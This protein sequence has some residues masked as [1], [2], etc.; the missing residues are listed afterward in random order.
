LASFFAYSSIYKEQLEMN[1]KKLSIYLRRA[2][3]SSIVVLTVGFLGFAV[4]AFST[5]DLTRLVFAGVAVVSIGILAL[6]F[7]LHR[8]TRESTAYS[9][10]RG[11]S[12]AKRSLL[13]RLFAWRSAAV[14]WMRGLGHSSPS[15]KASVKSGERLA[16]EAGVVRVEKLPDSQRAA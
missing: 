10:F 9:V 14:E 5:P 15:R 2:L 12:L 13:S 16:A 3:L 8:S 1:G 7:I 11:S 4:R 6:H